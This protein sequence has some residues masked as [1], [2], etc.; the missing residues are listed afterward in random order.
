LCAITTY[1]LD[2]FILITDTCV[3]MLRDMY[4]LKFWL[5][6]GAI[7]IAF[8]GIASAQVISGVAC[9]PYGSVTFNGEPAPDGMLVIAYVGDIELARTTTDG[10]QYSLYI[11]ADDPETPQ[12]DGYI[13]GD[14]I[15]VRVNGNSVDIAFEVFSGSQRR[16][17][18][19]LTSGIRLETWGRIKALFK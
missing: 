14:I 17:L 10:G 13:E 8:S 6:L 1:L 11:D 18:V 2:I 3:D 7:I 5:M 16:D 4:Y 12:R 15:N 9:E 19:V